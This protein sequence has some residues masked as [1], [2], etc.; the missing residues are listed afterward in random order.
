MLF[1]IDMRYEA[2]IVGV[3]TMLTGFFA[4]RQAKAAADAARQNG[5]D[6]QARS[7]DSIASL[8]HVKERLLDLS[9]H[10]L[11]VNET[12]TDHVNEENT[13]LD[14]VQRSLDEHIADSMPLLDGLT[15]KLD[16]HLAEDEAGG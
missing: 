7:E 8:E 14:Q 9:G 16:A 6:N 4:W 15:R 2:V 13:K 10:V 11:H 1:A 12:L 3:L 5:L